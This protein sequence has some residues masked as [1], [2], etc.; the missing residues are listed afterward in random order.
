MRILLVTHGFLPESSGGTEVHTYLLAKA[1]QG[2]HEVSV[3]THVSDPSRP[4]HALYRG[5]LDDL[6]VYSLVNN[7]TWGAG[8]EYFFY[9][10]GQDAPF[11]AVLDEVQPDVVH[12]HH[13]GGGLSTSFPGLVRGRGIPLLLTLHDFWPL[14][15]RSHLLT[16]EDLLCLGPD[17]GL[18]C[19]HCWQLDS[20]RPPSRLAQAREV[21]L[22]NALRMAPG[23]ILRAVG[24]RLVPLPG[25][26][27]TTRLLARDAYFRRLLTRFDLLLAPSQFL[28]D[29]YIDWGVAAERL[30]F[31]QNGVDP[32]SFS[33]LQRPL[34]NGERLSVAYLGSLLP[35]KGLDVLVEAANLL[36]D[37]PVDLHIYGRTEGSAATEAYVAGL[38]ARLRNPRLTFEGPYVPR[39]LGRVLSGADVV[40]VPSI[41]YENCPMAILEALYAGRPVVA[42]NAGG[43]A[44]LVR[45]G[46]NGLTFRLGDG[47]DLAARLRTL[48]H[49][50]QMLLAL[51]RGITPPQAMDAVAARVEQL[52]SDLLARAEG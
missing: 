37:A 10:R 45:D 9:D 27:H 35:H 4:E 13:L 2:R 38:R 29:R 20:L 26:Y 21:G 24:E 23:A 22:R 48:A 46:V 41:L 49:D 40:V 11:S 32:A 33:G 50:R 44:E 51:Q 39:D 5:D 42:S 31:V 12:M 36:A 14:C 1:L 18:R 3:C 15:Y 52:Y 43:M 17:D 25:G 47:A 19:A 7:F 34:P 28:R 16:A 30:L 8:S 6:P